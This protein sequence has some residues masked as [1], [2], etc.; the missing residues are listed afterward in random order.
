MQPAEAENRLGFRVDGPRIEFQQRDD[1]HWSA[2]NKNM[3]GTARS[4]ARPATPQEQQLWALLTEPAD[5]D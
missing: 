3:L 2:K 5:A 4:G 1:E